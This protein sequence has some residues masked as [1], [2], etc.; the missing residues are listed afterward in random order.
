MDNTDVANF[1]INVNKNGLSDKKTIGVVVSG[2]FD[3]SLLW[4]IVNEFT[5]TDQK[6]IPFT[7][8]KVD[9]ALTYATRMLEWY[10]K[11]KNTKRLHPIVINQE[12]VDWNRNDYQGDEVAQQLLNGIKEI[13]DNNMADVVFTGVNDYPPH[14]RT[15]CS[16]H[17]PAPRKKV[18]ESDYVHN[19]VPIN[20]IIKQPFADYTKDFLV[21]LAWELGILNDVAEFSHSCVEQIRGRCNECFWCKERSWAFQ[22]AGLS[23]IGKE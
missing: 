15:L 22:E 19:G 12:G 16:Y 20:E 13:V 2:G 3:S 8:P 9:G 6:V 17:T 5:G 21:R 11:L 7:V 10:S 23:D 18:S 4:Y 1:L 14:Y